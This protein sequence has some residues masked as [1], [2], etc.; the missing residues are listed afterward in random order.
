MMTGQQFVQG[1][2]SSQHQSGIG[3]PMQMNYQ[4]QAGTGPQ[5]Q[6]QPRNP[7]G[8]FA[9]RDGSM[10]VEY[11][12]GNRGG[13]QQLQMGSQGNVIRN[14]LPSNQISGQTHMGSQHVPDTHP[15]MAQQMGGVPM[16]AHQ[17]PHQMGQAS[18]S[19]QQYYMQQDQRMLNQPY[20][21]SQYPQNQF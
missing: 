13:R 4:G 20:N 17:L 8:Q 19:G 16:G 2:S 1:G 21:H 12:Q 5:P 15:M 18:M 14:G 7:M 9:S 3:G 11:Q 10:N 6:Q